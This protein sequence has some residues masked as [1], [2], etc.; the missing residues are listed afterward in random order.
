MVPV[1]WIAAGLLLLLVGG[2]IVVRGAG[3]LAI[4]LGVRPLVVGLTVVAFSTSTPELAASLTATLAGSPGLALGNVVGSNIANIGLILGLCGVFRE[5][6]VQSAFLRREAPLLVLSGLVLLLFLRNG[7][8]SRPESAAL[9]VLLTAYVSTMVYMESRAARDAIDAAVTAVYPE[10]GTRGGQ[11]LLVLSGVALLVVGANRLVLGATSVAEALGVP[12]RVI[13]LTVVAVGT[14]LPELASS[15]AATSKGHGDLV[16]GNVVG[17]NIFNVL[18]ILGVTGLI[19]PMD[20][21]AGPITQDLWVMIG[22]SMALVWLLHRGRTL[23]RSEAALLLASYGV[24]VFL[25]L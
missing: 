9:L 25:L 22:F 5:I 16:L 23:F 17:S 7:V 15:L 14:S 18:C 3:R 21:G 20:G 6:R 2:E 12:E 11:L 8:L 10:T 1:L 4:L 19:A 13:G 24:Y